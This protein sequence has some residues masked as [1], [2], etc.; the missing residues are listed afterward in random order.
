M[1]LAE[2]IQ[3]TST[4]KYILIL[5]KYVYFPITTYLQHFR[6][7]N[8][9][10]F[11]LKSYFKSPILNKMEGKILFNCKKLLVSHNEILSNKM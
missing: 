7:S 2:N 6:Q 3:K 5:V 8:H 1:H 11:I 10:H 9:I 4:L